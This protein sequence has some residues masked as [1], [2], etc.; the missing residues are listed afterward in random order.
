MPF[1]YET[2]DVCG[3]G[4]VRIITDSLSGCGKANGVSFSCDWGQFGM[5]GGVMD[6]KDV[7][8]LLKDLQE[9]VEHDRKGDLWQP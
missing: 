7:K 4:K 6:R 8:R 1:N 3:A 9:W 5:C 2:Y